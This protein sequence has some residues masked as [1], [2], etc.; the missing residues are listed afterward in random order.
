MTPYK[1]NALYDVHKEF[2]PDRFKQTPKGSEKLD[3]IDE[4][5]GGF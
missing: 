2:N 5:L 3:P 4:A 1:L